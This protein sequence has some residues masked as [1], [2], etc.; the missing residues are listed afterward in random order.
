MIRFFHHICMTP[1]HGGM[2][3]GIHSCRV[4]EF[5][6]VYLHNARDA[7]YV[8]YTN[9]SFLE[10]YYYYKVYVYHTVLLYSELIQA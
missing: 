8:S 2:N 3:A 6:P 5:D 7:V 1:F 10:Y 4:H 9:D